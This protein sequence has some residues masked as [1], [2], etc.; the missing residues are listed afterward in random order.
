MLKHALLVSLLLAMATCAD[1]A[2]RSQVQLGISTRGNGSVEAGRV[3]AALAAYDFS[4]ESLAREQVCGAVGPC[5]WPASGTVPTDNI[6]DLR[7]FDDGTLRIEYLT[8]G[9]TGTGLQFPSS[10]QNP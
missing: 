9:A 1:R 6:S 3:G 7:R 10:V 2:E 8:V 5:F 4:L